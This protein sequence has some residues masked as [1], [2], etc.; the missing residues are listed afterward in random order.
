MSHNVV[1]FLWRS[2]LVQAIRRLYVATA[3]ELAFVLL[4]FGAVLQRHTPVLLDT[5]PNA[6]E[7]DS[8]LVSRRPTHV[9]FGPDTIYNRK[10]LEAVVALYSASDVTENQTEPSTALN[11]SLVSDVSKD[12]AE[13]AVSQKASVHLMCAALQ[14]P[15]VG[16]SHAHARSLT[17]TIYRPFGF[18]TSY[19]YAIEQ[20]RLKLQRMYSLST[21]DEYEDVKIVVEDLSG[22][23]FSK[24]TNSYRPEFVITMFMAFTITATRRLNAIGY[25]LSTGLAVG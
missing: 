22:W 20:A 1:T 7:L 10:L 5:S 6:T 18:S 19:M 23:V 15:E 4:S 17:Y 11:A 12:C 14:T 13:I 24:M 25:E 9:V 8:L 16:K 2:L 21:E 3:L